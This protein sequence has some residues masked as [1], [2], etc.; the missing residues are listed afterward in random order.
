MSNKEYI[1]WT[2]V[3]EVELTK[4]TN[5]QYDIFDVIAE[6]HYLRKPGAPEIDVVA[7]GI[8]MMKLVEKM[9]NYTDPYLYIGETDL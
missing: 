9:S 6:Q 3:R 7:H 5:S 2:E 1:D 4:D 8:L